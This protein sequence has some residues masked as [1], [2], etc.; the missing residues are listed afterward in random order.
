MKH[1]LY[2]QIQYSYIRIFSR[3]YNKE[4][5]VTTKQGFDMYCRGDKGSVE[6]DLIM[7]RNYESEI[8]QFII[9]HI[10]RSEYFLDIGANIGF[11]SLLIAKL[12]P[13]M[14]IVSFEPI[15]ETYDRLV[16]NI[17]VNHFGQIQSRNIGLAN[18]SRKID[19][20]LD[21]ELG[22]ISLL[23]REGKIETIEIKRLDDVC[24]LTNKR[25]FIKID[26]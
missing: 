21:T 10:D 20:H 5:L 16:R 8:S 9:D 18:E 23:K 4:Q 3:Y 19:I 1:P 14:S 13:S 25:I 15:K 17:E 22:H 24:S 26:V 11:Y 2:K 7:G 12:K 6:M